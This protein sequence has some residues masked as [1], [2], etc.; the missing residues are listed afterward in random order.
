MMR[1]IREE[2]DLKTR[3]ADD[4][5]NRRHWPGHHATHPHLYELIGYIDNVDVLVDL[6]E[7][8]KGWEKP[9][10][11]SPVGQILLID[12]K[13]WTRHRLI[14]DGMPH[15]R[16]SDIPLTFD[17]MCEL[18]IL[19]DSHGLMGPE[20]SHAEWDLDNKGEPHDARTEPQHA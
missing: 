2:P 15:P 1:D 10:P 4:D 12:G 8:R 19:L 5:V 9:S 18:C 13:T 14:P 6:E 16:D 17:Q 3:Y 11:M 7:L 20:P